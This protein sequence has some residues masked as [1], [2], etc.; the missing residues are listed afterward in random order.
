MGR[1]L[2]RIRLEHRAQRIKTVMGL[3]ESRRDERRTAGAPVP[4]AL[5]RA[6][7]GFEAELLAVDVRLD[8]LEAG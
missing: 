4:A 5:D 6:I 2:E 3:L 8:D 1:E 7:G